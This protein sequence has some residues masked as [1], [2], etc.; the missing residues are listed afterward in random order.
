MENALQSFW[1]VVIIVISVIMTLIVLVGRAIEIATIVINDIIY[2]FQKSRNSGE[3]AGP[4]GELDTQ[5]FIE[6]YSS[7]SFFFQ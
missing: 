6:R 7:T 4:D 5:L 3:E 1:L 2:W